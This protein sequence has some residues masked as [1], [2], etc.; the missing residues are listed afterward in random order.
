MMNI[1]MLWY[2]ND[3]KVALK[4]KVERAAAYYRRKYGRIP[5]VC[6]VH[7]KMLG[8]LPEQRV[9]TESE[10]AV[11]SNRLIQPGHLWIGE[12]DKN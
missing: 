5:D 9:G 1:G 6:F 12:D 8:S 3:P 2:D 4:E 11:R 7:P 10:V